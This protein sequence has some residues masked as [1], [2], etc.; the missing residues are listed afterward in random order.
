MENKYSKRQTQRYIE[1]CEY[2]DNIKK[3]WE[4]VS[5]SIEKHK[6]SCRPPDI[7]EMENHS[8]NVQ[9]LKNRIKERQNN[10]E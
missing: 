6:G 8:I 10:Q 5:E 7:P 4:R 9:D 3:F 1:L 2:Y